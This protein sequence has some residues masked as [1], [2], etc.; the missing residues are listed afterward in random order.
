[1]HSRHPI[2]VCVCA[3]LL[4]TV[5]V[6]FIVIA[7]RST[8]QA[9]DASLIN[10]FK[11]HEP[12]FKSLATM[13]M[14]DSHILMIRDSVVSIYQDGAANPY[15]YLNK[16]KTWPASEVELNFSELRWEY[17]R[18]AFRKLD[19]RGGME[20]TRNLPGTVFFEAAVEVSELDNDERAVITK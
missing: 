20:R 17:Y 8:S 14:Q 9:S 11:S 19:L 3:V 6:T 4:G 10:N 1:M 16:G 13:Y 5:I 12:Q 15:V 2:V 7:A 18:D